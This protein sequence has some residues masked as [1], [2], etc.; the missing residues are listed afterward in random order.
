MQVRG[1]INDDLGRRGIWV[2]REEERATL[3]AIFRRLVLSL[4]YQIY[5]ISF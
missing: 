5:V 1:D 2:L 3:D 4:A